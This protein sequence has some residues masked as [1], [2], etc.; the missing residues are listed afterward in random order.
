MSR[1]LRAYWAAFCAEVTEA[2]SWRSWLVKRMR[3]SKGSAIAA[4]SL[5]L[6]GIGV[7]V[8][9]VLGAREEEGVCHGERDGGFEKSCSR[10]S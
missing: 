8:V 6:R 1:F 4:I 7:V 9:D 2:L 3:T 10:A 5:A